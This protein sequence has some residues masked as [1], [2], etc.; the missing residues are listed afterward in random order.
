MPRQE[1]VIRLLLIEDHLEDAEGL[2]SIL[3]NG[4]IAV[5][6]QRPENAGEL[7]SL[8]SA[9]QG[10]DLVLASV[11]AKG[12]PFAQVIEA[13]NASGKDIPV[14]A[15]L[16]TLDEHAV[17]S[18]LEAGARS[19]ALRTRPQHLQFVVRNEFGSLD[20]RRA[21]RRLEGALRET[22]RRCDS[23]ISSSRDPIAYVH[24]G[25]HIRA[26]E[27]Y[28]EMFGY[29]SFEEIEV[30][31]LLDMVAPSHAGDFKQLLKQLS[32]G[33]PPPKTLQI[34]AQRADGST[35]DAVMEFAQASYEGEPCQQIIFRQKTLDADMAREL[36][37]LR[38]RDQVTGLFNRQHFLGELETTIADAVG[39]RGSQALLL[40]QPDNHAA[41]LADIGLAH[42]DELLLKL[43]ER[44]QSA[45]DD[46]CIAA[47]FTDH[48]FAVLCSPGDFAHGQ[49]IAERIRQA[50]HGHIIEAGE[51]SLSLTVSIGGV[52]ISEKIASLQQVLAKAGQCLQSAGAVAGNRIEIYDPAARDRAEEERALRWVEDIR[53]ALAADGFVL[54]YQPVIS[55]QGEEGETYEVFLRMKG[56]TDEIF[57]PADFL[58]IAEEHGLLDEI[59]RWVV[60]R[61]TQVLA[62]RHKAGKRTTLF[63]KVSASSLGGDGI[64]TYIGERLRKSG[65]PGE[66]LVLEI[67]EA[68]VFTN[69]KPAQE[70]QRTVN[71]H[72]CRI[73]LEQFGAGLNSFQL[74]SHFDPHFL[75]IDRSFMDD[76]AKNTENQAKVREIA[77]RARDAGKQTIAEFVQDAGSM[78]VLFSSG[79][80]F[81]EGHFLAPPGPDMNY[82]FG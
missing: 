18:A 27:A 76:L 20:N 32:K 48:S 66:R 22:E 74:L 82:D 26:N 81:V 25:M 3:R 2:I 55:L 33:E 70:F 23:L 46:K 61:A 42:A 80:D 56:N 10:V 79:V 15:T 51:R 43:A 45:L 49:T 11:D 6:P 5:R 69:L 8:L 39:G 44:L 1:S 13:V 19:V 60:D 71:K 54:H 41:L 78:T 37:A 38:Q 53:A 57:P 9:S 35:F 64:S 40:I 30:L 17:I 73:A 68:R 52:Q 29:E 77:T 67:P 50:F 14:I 65:A 4:G 7:R 21:L 75:K 63:V 58:P 59:D 34:A 28:L 12:I 31:S 72:G 47:R 16:Q 36:D 62:E 24:E